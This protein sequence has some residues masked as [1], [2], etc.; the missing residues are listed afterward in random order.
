MDEGKLMLNRLKNKIKR[1]VDRYTEEKYLNAIIAKKKGIYEFSNKDLELYKIERKTILPV[2]KVISFSDNLKNISIAN[3]KIFWPEIVADDDLPWLYHEIFDLFD[4][5][6]SSYNHPDLNYEDADWIIDAGCCEGY[7]SLFSFDKNPNCS[8]IALEPLSEM[9]ESLHKTFEEKMLDGKFILEQ[10]AL[11]KDCGTVKFQFNSEHLCDSSVGEST[12]V[13]E[14]RKDIFY[15]VATINLDTLMEQ[16]NLNENGIIKMDIEGAEMDALQ[17]GAELMRKHKPKLA[18]AVYHEY[19]NAMKC[20]DI[21]LKAN[22]K[23]QVEFRGMYGYFNPPRP[24][25]LFAW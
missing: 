7:F 17:G 24:Y 5:N 18:V 11:G 21:I 12:F 10:K 2:K 9:K 1:V 15:D 19:E 14:N 4:I 22:P 16:Y 23:Y 20:K 13:L 8:L 3:H 6:P 25:I